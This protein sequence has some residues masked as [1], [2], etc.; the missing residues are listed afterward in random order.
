MTLNSWANFASRPWVHLKSPN[1]IHV[2]LTCVFSLRLSHSHQGTYGEKE[3]GNHAR[4]KEARKYVFREMRR[5][6]LWRVTWSGTVSDNSN[7]WSQLDLLSVGF[8]SCRDFWWS[9]C[10]H[11]CTVLI[12][13]KAH[14]Y[15][16]QS[17]SVFS[18]S[19]VTYLTN[20]CTW[21]TSRIICVCMYWYS[22][23]EW[24]I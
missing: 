17:S 16:W 20:T 18:L 19:P 9:L 2:S 13:I 5:D 4:R 14:N 11:T 7:S 6:F 3:E 21:I 10:R 23:C 1:C 22:D 8:N 12:L 15:Q 24:S